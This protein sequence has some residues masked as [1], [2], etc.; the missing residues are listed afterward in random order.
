MLTLGSA[1]GLTRQVEEGRSEHDG[2]VREGMIKFS[3]A[4]RFDASGFTRD[5]R[6]LVFQRITPLPTLHNP[7]VSRCQK[8]HGYF[9]DYQ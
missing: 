8:G 7:C 2:T 1:E 4:S 5:P 6:H 3:E 9:L